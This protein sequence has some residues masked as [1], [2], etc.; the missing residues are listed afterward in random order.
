M[1]MF[2]ALGVLLASSMS[3][4]AFT[5]VSGDRSV[6]RIPRPMNLNMFMAEDARREVSNNAPYRFALNYNVNQTALEQG[7]WEAGANGEACAEEPPLMRTVR[8]PGAQ[9]RSGGEQAAAVDD[10]GARGGPVEQHLR[11]GSHRADREHDHR[12]RRAAGRT[13]GDP[14]VADRLRSSR[15]SR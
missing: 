11:E 1:K 4:A 14:P 2:W 6:L 13:R 7:T 12:P 5:P 9:E 8:R 3:F 10:G 15:D